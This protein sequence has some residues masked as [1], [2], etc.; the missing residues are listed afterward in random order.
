M[1]LHS[2][3]ITSNRKLLSYQQVTNVIELM[4]PTVEASKFPDL[5]AGLVRDK[6]LNEVIALYD[7][8][9]ILMPTF[10]PHSI[11]TRDRLLEYFTQ[12]TEREGLSVNLHENTQECRKISEKDYVLS[13]IYSWQFKVDD[14]L[15]TFP[16][17]FTFVLDLSRDAPIIH[18]HSSQMP[19]TLS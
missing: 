2:D 9:S 1:P 14:T 12:L 7:S 5:W 6:K 10:S 11:K 19:R 16:S 13:G 18:H 15:L 8:A 17:R 4:Q 3:P